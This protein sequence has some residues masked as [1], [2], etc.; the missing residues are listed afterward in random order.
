MD[1][2]SYTL[3]YYQN[4][5]ME[6][7]YQ[8]KDVLVKDLQLASRSVSESNLWSS[9]IYPEAAA[10]DYYLYQHIRGVLALHF[11]PEEPLPKIWA[12][13]LYKLSETMNKEIPRALHYMMLICLQE[14][15]HGMDA[16]S[17]FVRD[18]MIAAHGAPLET[19]IRNYNSIS[20]PN[21]FW[22]DCYFNADSLL[23][24]KG[25]FGA[26]ATAFTTYKYSGGFGG[27]PWADVSTC[28][29][30]LFSGVI[31]PSMMMDTVWTLCHN[32]GPIFNK[33]YL[34]NQYNLES[35]Q[36]ILDCQRAGLLPELILESIGFSHFTQSALGIAHKMQ[37]DPMFKV[38]QYL[39]WYTVAARGAV[40]DHTYKK[41]KQVELHGLSPMAS[42][43]E[44]IQAAKALAVI[45][46]AAKDKEEF[47]KN[48]YQVQLG[49]FVPKF[50]RAA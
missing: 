12:E 38:S 9:P 37:K 18:K 35:L 43:M 34:Y 49:V 32:N 48:N 19:A 13:Q 47:A 15:R 21:A 25:F 2:P 39:D 11:A 20:N 44:K 42:E 23:P 17:P 4:L 31:A 40:F 45:Q 8:F 1:Y 5:P 50:Q 36:N 26:L 28:V 24:I 10:L 30:N 27:K 33:G 46:K 7:T 29:E 22:R 41:Q 16:G 3:Q 14:G 6:K